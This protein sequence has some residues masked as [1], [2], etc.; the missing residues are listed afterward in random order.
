MLPGWPGRLLAQPT[1]RLT[2]VTDDAAS[3]IDLSGRLAL[4]TDSTRRLTIGSVRRLPGAPFRPQPGNTLY[5]PA[6]GH[7]NNWIR[8]R[9]FNATQRT[10]PMVLGIDHP[11]L[12]SVS[13]YVFADSGLAYQAHIPGWR[14]PVHQRPI[15]SYNFDFPLDLGPQ[16]TYTVYLKVWRERGTLAIPV[17]L[18]RRDAYFKATLREKHRFGIVQGVLLLMSGLGLLLFWRVRRW[19][20]FWY[21]IQSLMMVLFTAG[22]QGMLNPYA[23]DLFGVKSQPAAYT[24]LIVGLVVSQFLF[25]IRFVP[26]E[27]LF[28]R[29]LARLYHAYPLGLLLTLMLYLL[30]PSPA[31]ELVQNFLVIGAGVLLVGLMGA[32]LYRRYPTAPVYALADLPFIMVSIVQLFGI[33]TGLTIIEATRPLLNYA[34]LF[35]V[36]TLY[37]GLVMR[38]DNYRRQNTQLLTSLTQTQRRLIEVQESERRR[39]AQDLHDDVG[40]TLAAAKNGLVH[41]TNPAALVRVDGLLEKASRDLRTITHNL[42]PVEFDKYSLPDVVRQ[43]TERAG[44]A[45][46]TRFEFIMAGTERNFSDEQSLAIYRICN[47]LITNIL[48]YANASLAVVQLVYQPDVL[49]I[50]VEDDGVGF[51]ATKAEAGTGIGLRNIASRAGYIGATFEISSSAAGTLALLEVPYDKKLLDVNR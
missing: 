21:G 32:G 14:Q 6:W 5:L 38:F 25:A 44:A 16:R 7:T 48:K 4:L 1:V 47:E 28:P 8:L 11:T 42:L 15:P 37:I 45:G 10:Q 46:P 24:V 43:S 36:V 22:R 13:V 51:S 17:R 12:D 31:R 3:T 34:P 41:A 9:L 23:L 26:V 49:V 40:N 20:Y 50:T 2:E 19:V 18:S 30:S 39:I 33:S 27:S 29:W 35:E